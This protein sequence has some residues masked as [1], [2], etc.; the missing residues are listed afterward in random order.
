[1]PPENDVKRRRVTLAD[2]AEIAGVSIKTVS[3]V[4][5]GNPTVRLPDT[6][7]QRVRDAAAQV[8]YRANRFAQAI[9]SGKTDL[10]SVWIP[11]ERFNPNMF[12]FLRAISEK[13]RCTDHGLLVSG[14]DSQFA[15]AG[16][17]E[18]PKV[19]PVDGV[20]AVDAGKSIISFRED[21]RNDTIPVSVLGFEEFRNSDS[22]GWEVAVASRLLTNNLIE[23]GCKRIA[24]L[25]LDWVLQDYPREQRRRGY[26]E[27]MD[28]AGLETTYL[29]ARGE[30]GHAAYITMSEYLAENPVPDAIICFSDRLAIGAIQAIQAKGAKVPDD[31]RIWGYGD[32]PEG[33]DWNV[34]ISSIRIPIQDLVDQSWEWLLSRIE[35]PLIETRLARFPMELVE[36]SSG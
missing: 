30:D 5:S 23:K 11:M 22:I 15:Y 25:T 29:A 36:R 8:G 20:I 19:W 26:T 17:G 12:L 32:L 31:C 9:Q 27:A 24:H 13:A 16:Q 14:L 6:T 33:Q 35:N 7:R 3:H 1:M 28:D 10:I 2:V 21:P 18:S 34:P 4:L